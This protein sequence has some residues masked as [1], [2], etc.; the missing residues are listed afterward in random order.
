MTLEAPSYVLRVVPRSLMWA[1]LC[2]RN[3]FWAFM[4]MVRAERG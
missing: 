1:L 4:G 3:Q 2:L